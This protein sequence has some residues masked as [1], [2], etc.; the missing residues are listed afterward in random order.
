[1]SRVGRKAEIEGKS[2]TTLVY[3]KISEEE[4]KELEELAEYLEIPK[5]TLTRNLIL[6]GIEDAKIFKKT[7]LL[8]L[9]KG[10]RKSGEWL[11]EFRQIKNESDD[12]PQ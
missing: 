12:L 11:K 6:S 10:I 7:G 8:G 5:M 1:M 4:A 9:A 3:A 2:K